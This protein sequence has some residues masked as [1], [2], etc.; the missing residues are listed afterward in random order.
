MIANIIK[1][2]WQH[3]IADNF[4][5][6]ECLAEVKSVDHTVT[7]VIAGKRVDSMRLFI[8]D[9]HATQ[10]PQLYKLYC[11]LHHGEYRD[12]F[13]NYTGIDYS[14]LF[15]RVEVISDIGEFY[16][17]PHYDL[18]EKRL[19]ALIYTDHERLYPG[20]GL[21]NGTRVDSKD[22][23]CFFFVPGQHSLHDYPLTTFETVRR[24]LQIN[25]WTYKDRI[26]NP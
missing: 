7:Q 17:E 9:S 3:W 14:T 26:V 24:C 10:Y 6:A 20:T 12:F 21:G 19:S 5:T 16:L 4:L 15:P 1:T 11:S 13:E 8:N 25:Y 22:N 23:R 18:K 2:P